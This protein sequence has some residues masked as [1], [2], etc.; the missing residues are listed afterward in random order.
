MYFLTEERPPLVLALVETSNSLC[1]DMD[2]FRHLAS[3]LAIL[4][5]GQPCGRVVQRRRQARC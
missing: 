1:A 3:G 4:P 5:Y 2:L